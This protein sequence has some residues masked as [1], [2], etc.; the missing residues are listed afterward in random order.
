VE[1]RHGAS[2]WNAGS[3]DTDTNT[4]IVGVGKL[5]I[6]AVGLDNQKA[7]WSFRTRAAQTGAVLTI[8]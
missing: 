3:Y 7:A 4:F 6:I 1:K 5:G 8:S 2:T